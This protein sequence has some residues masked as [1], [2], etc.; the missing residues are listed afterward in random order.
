VEGAAAWDGCSE[1]AR[2]GEAARR[3]ASGVGRG[4][5]SGS[6]WGGGGGGHGVG[7]RPRR[8][9]R[10]GE[11]ADEGRGVGRDG[12]RGAQLPRRGGDGDSHGVGRA[13]ERLR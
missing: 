12:R 5:P 6:A 9:L 11:T 13:V 3:C 8:L 4:V 2:R 7:Q 10:R 1:W